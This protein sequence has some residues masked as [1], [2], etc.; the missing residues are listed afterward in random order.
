LHTLLAQAGPAK[1]LEELVLQIKIIKHSKNIAFCIISGRNFVNCSQKLK[2]H[3]SVVV[4][5][6]PTINYHCGVSVLS[7][8]NLKAIAFL[9]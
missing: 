8:N 3:L 9:T 4:G 5:E 2:P 6:R 7:K 1:N